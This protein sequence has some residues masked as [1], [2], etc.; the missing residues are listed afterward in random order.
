MKI[1][2]EALA[3][4][5]KRVKQGEKYSHISTELVREIG[6]MEYIKGRNLKETVK[7]VRNKLHQVGSAFQEKPIPYADWTKALHTL[8]EDLHAPA[9]Q[10]F[11]QRNL[12]AH[13]STHER[14]PILDRFFQETLASIGPV[15]SILDLACGLTPL[16]LP[17]MPLTPKVKYRAL[18]IYEDMTTF[19]N[20]F[21][22]HFKIDGSSG[23]CDLSH[24]I[25][26][27][28]AQVAFLLKTIPCLE[29]LDKQVGKRLLTGLK[30]ENI[31][32][33]FPSRSLGGRSK[34][35]LQN[36]EAH[37]CALVEDQP[38]KTTRYE[39]PGELAFL[40]QK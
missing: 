19:I 23:L 21:F 31:L 9:C 11:I 7:T 34:G 29:Q 14:L 33:S 25:P 12:S 4:L 3:D 26:S 30:T 32:V 18:D 13:A 37:F 28:P 10:D 2:E 16:T 36:Y 22:A 24:E 27:E 1:S 15:E 40:I 20:Q 8:P 17:W 5:V 35:M 38:W 39:F 6:R